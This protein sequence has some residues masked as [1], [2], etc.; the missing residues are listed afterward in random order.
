MKT[1]K[2]FIIG[3]FTLLLWGFYCQTD[4]YPQP[5]QFWDNYGFEVGKTY[6]QIDM[7]PNPFRPE[8]AIADTLTVEAIKD[9][10]IKFEGSEW[11]YRLNSVGMSFYKWEEL[12]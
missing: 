10:Y 5:M 3:F 12:K 9:G 8:E 1:W 7:S 6:L 2:L 4:N 11:T